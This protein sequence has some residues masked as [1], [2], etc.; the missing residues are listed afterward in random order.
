MKKKNYIIHLEGGGN[1]S[2]PNALKIFEDDIK[3]TYMIHNNEGY[4]VTSL[5]VGKQDVMHIEEITII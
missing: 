3:T 2:I 4:I 1:I 5:D